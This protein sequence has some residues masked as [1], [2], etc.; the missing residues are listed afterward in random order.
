MTSTEEA[1]STA[2][3]HEN[4]SCAVDKGQVCVLW[5]SARFQGAVMG[6]TV[7][8]SCTGSSHADGDHEV[9]CNRGHSLSLNCSSRSVIHDGLCQRLMSCRILA[10]P[11]Q[12]PDFRNS[13]FA[14]CKARH[15][16]YKKF[17]T[18]QSLGRTHTAYH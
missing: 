10:D 1:R 18:V 8:P 4:M 9:G 15:Q 16:H 13:R 6:G 14:V 5:L 2:T 17:G 3:A 12:P 11:R 7:T